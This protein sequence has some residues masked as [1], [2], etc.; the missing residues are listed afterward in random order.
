MQIKVNEHEAR[1]W[2]GL[3]Q[4][5]RTNVESV[6]LTEFEKGVI[7]EKV[8][9]FIAKLKKAAGEVKP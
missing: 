7:Y 6:A 9:T 3:A 4:Q 2:L 5:Y 1:L 8:D